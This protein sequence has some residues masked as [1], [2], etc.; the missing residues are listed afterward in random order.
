MSLLHK[1]GQIYSILNSFLFWTTSFTRYFKHFL[2]NFPLEGGL[3]SLA[4]K[5][6]TQQCA[7]YAEN[8]FME[9]LCCD[10]RATQQ[11]VS[12]AENCCIITLCCNSR[13]TQQVVCYAENCFMKT[14]LWHYS[15]ATT[16]L[17]CRG[18]F[19]DDILLWL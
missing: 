3:F 13:A 11:L 7:C 10:T 4:N 14:V 17:L 5:W 18:L 2:K 9:T 16:Y 19:S 1:T 15:S 8:C 6:V 12:Y